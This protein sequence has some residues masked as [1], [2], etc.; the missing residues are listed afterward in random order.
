MEA[1]IIAG[2]EDMIWE[3]GIPEELFPFFD[4]FPKSVR[5]QEYYFQKIFD[6]QIVNPL[7]LRLFLKFFP[8]ALP[9]FLE[10]LK[11]E[12]LDLK[13]MEKMID[14][15]KKSDTARAQEIYREI[16]GISNEIF[17]VEVLKAMYS[18]PGFDA[19]FLLPGLNEAGVLLKREILAVLS[20]D[21]RY[22]KQIFETLFSIPSPWGTKNH[23]IMENLKLIEELQIKE[24]EGYLVELAK[25]RFFWNW[26]LRRKAQSLL[27]EWHD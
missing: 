13:L 19:S 5:G 11:Q 16:F 17:K 12:R 22:N 20:K 4:S 2:I 26:N 27:K 8:Q 10:R 23:L 24:A 21:K 14:S 15:L 7:A 18:L 1:K 3:D 9:E 25:K 6:E